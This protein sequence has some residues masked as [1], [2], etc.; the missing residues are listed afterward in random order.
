MKYGYVLNIEDTP[1]DNVWT[2]GRE[3]TLKDDSVIYGVEGV[4]LTGATIIGNGQEFNQWLEINRK[5]DENPS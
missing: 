3:I 4:D 5:E 1:S 2:E